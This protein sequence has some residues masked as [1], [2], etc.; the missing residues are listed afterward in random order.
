M[1]DVKAIQLLNDLDDSGMT[2]FLEDLVKSRDGED[3]EVEGVDGLTEPQRRRVK[4]A[5]RILGKLAK[6]FLKTRPVDEDE[7]DEELPDAERDEEDEEPDLDAPEQDEETEEEERPVAK[8]KIKPPRRGGYAFGRELNDD[9]GKVKTPP[10]E[11][12]AQRMEKSAHGL[13]ELI[14]SAAG[15][16]VV[17]KAASSGRVTLPA[18]ARHKITQI[19][20]DIRKSAGAITDEVARG[21][22]GR[23]PQGRA[24]LALAD[25]AARIGKANAP[26]DEALA[27]LARYPGLLAGMAPALGVNG[28]DVVTAVTKAAAQFPEYGFGDSSSFEG[29]PPRE[30]PS[31]STSDGYKRNE[32][33]EIPRR[34]RGEDAKTFGAR[35]AAY[36]DKIAAGMN[37]A[38]RGEA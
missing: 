23:S 22:A 10:P 38:D 9:T 17:Q 18:L 25:E 3:D 31:G 4:A 15:A 29:N 21:M 19:A 8:K 34:K 26:D 11:L 28:Q 12:D 2:P 35:Y 6:R 1:D 30:T 37:R 33:L 24:W 13:P 16:D 27:A 14:H 32:R 20:A 7:E 5:A 36:R